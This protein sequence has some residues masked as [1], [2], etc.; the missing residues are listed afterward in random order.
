M[1]FELRDGQGS[2]FIND[3]KQTDRQPDRTGS[4]MIGGKMYRVSGWIKSGA[5]GQF[6]SLAFTPADAQ[7]DHQRERPADIKPPGANAPQAPRYSKTQLRDD[8]EIPF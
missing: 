1:A 7:Q 6:L 5:K 8:E 4:A 3:R 2:L